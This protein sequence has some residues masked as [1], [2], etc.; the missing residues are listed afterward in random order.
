MGV[1]LTQAFDSANAE[2]FTY[3]GLGLGVRGVE[4]MIGQNNGCRFQIKATNGSASGLYVSGQQSSTT[5]FPAVH[6]AL[7]LMGNPIQVVF[8][9]A[10]LHRGRIVLHNE[11]IGPFGQWPVFDNSVNVP[12]AT[13]GVGL[14]SARSAGR[15]H[16]CT[17]ICSCNR[18][19]TVT[20]NVGIGSQTFVIPALFDFPGATGGLGAFT[21]IVVPDELELLAN[22]LDAGLAATFQIGWQATF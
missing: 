6:V 4:L 1:V 12:A 22:N 19:S 20:A 8:Q 17:L 10:T 21:F 11:P 2:T 13:S 18:Q 14:I 7:P 16:G 9:D 15:P 5:S 3:D